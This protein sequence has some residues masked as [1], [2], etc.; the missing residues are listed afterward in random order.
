MGWK[1][2]PYYGTGYG[3]QLQRRAYPILTDGQISPCSSPIKTKQ[4]SNAPPCLSQITHILL[5]V[6]FQKEVL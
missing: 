4:D 5:N 1:T 2:V 6:L 3:A